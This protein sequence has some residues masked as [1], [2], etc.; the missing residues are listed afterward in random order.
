ME[1]SFQKKKNLIYYIDTK[2]RGKIWIPWKIIWTKVVVKIDKVRKKLNLIYI[3]FNTLQESE[4]V[5]KGKG[6]I[7][8]IYWNT[9]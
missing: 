3:F 8:K 4:K 9:E 6:N 2:K 5:K 1:C 7:H